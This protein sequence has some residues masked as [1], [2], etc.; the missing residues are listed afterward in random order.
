MKKLNYWHILRSRGYRPMSLARHGGDCYY[1]KEHLFNRVLCHVVKDHHGKGTTM[2]FQ[3]SNGERVP[4]D[5]SEFLDAEFDR[6]YLAKEAKMVYTRFRDLRD[7]VQ[8]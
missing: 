4:K 1:V 2:M 6:S 8:A 7:G 3:I 5:M